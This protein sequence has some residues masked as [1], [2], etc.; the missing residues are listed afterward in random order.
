MNWKRIVV[1]L[2]V[3]ALA[4]VAVQGAFAKSQP[5]PASSAKG[6]GVVT[7]SEGVTWKE[8]VPGSVSTAQVEGDMAKGPSH[9]F[10]KYN[11]GFVTPVHHHSANH[12]VSLVK[13]TLV[14]TVDG[15]DHTLQPGSYFALTGKKSHTAR[16]DGSED[17]VMF[18]DARSPWDVV[19]E[20]EATKH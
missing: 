6:M 8:V 14:L 5:K 20:T 9:F 16:C 12:Y 7:S 1:G 2:V 19:P 17:C 4:V 13:G 3:A 15:K 18:V 11:A 10:L